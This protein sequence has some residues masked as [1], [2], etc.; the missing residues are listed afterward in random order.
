MLCLIWIFKLITKVHTKSYFVR[1]LKRDRNCLFS[2]KWKCV[3]E[4]SSKVIYKDCEII[5]LQPSS[6]LLPPQHT[7][8]LVVSSITKVM[9]PIPILPKS[10]WSRCSLGCSIEYATKLRIKH[11]VLAL[12]ELVCSPET[13]STENLAVL[14]LKALLQWFSFSLC[15]FWKV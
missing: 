3:E 2:L 5:N 9:V 1:L 7:K 10:R 15:N 6:P 12:L 14:S 8:R 4:S 11:V 13:H